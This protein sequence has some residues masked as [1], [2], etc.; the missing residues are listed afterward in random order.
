MDRLKLHI[1]PCPNDTFMFEAVLRGRIDTEG[2]EFETVFMDIERLN[3]AL[4]EGE[5]ADGPDISKASFSVVP[6]VSGS[7]RILP[8]GAALGRGNGPVVVAPAPDTDLSDSSLRIAVPGLH[9]TANLLLNKLYP[10]L[11]D[12]LPLLFSDIADALARKECD[13]GVL[14]HEGRFTYRERGLY[15]LADL[16]ER[17][18]QTTGLPLPLGVILVSRR[19]PEKVQKSVARVLRRSIEY[20]FGHP[21]ASLDF[22]RSH[23]QELSEE[24]MRKH[25]ECFV[26]GFSLSLGAEGRRA[27]SELLGSACPDDMFV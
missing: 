14:I 19:L 8:S 7:Y 18:E 27:V 11:R 21:E 22:V 24:V 15:L 1:S 6:A 10:Q 20:A 13:A 17:W 23:A 12:R 2:L 9:T 3:N 26:N 25:I 5:D 16:G 4:L